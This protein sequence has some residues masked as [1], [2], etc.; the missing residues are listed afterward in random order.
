MDFIRAVVE[1]VWNGFW[2]LVDLLEP[3]IGSIL[4]RLL[5]VD[6]APG[7]ATTL[8]AA[9]VLLIFFFWLSKFFFSMNKSAAN[10]PM[11]ITLTTDKSPAQVVAEDREKHLKAILAMGG[12]VAIIYLLVR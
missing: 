12:V 5:D 4:G 2:S 6:V 3:L 7:G 9:L 8:T 11:K 10:G 1:A